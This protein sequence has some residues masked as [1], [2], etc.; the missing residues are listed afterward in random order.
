MLN[1]KVK[2]PL[3]L[4]DSGVGGYLDNGSFKALL[5]AAP[6][7]VPGDVDDVGGVAAR[8]TGRPAAAKRGDC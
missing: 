8:E 1:A 7:T 5:T 3:L 2:Y 6:I 4:T